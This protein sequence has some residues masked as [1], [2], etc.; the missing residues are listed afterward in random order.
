[1]ET[2]W[3]RDQP[4]L[5]IGDVKMTSRTWWPSLVTNGKSPPRGPAS[6]IDAL[7]QTFGYWAIEWKNHSNRQYIF[8]KDSFQMLVPSIWSNTLSCKHSF[9]PWKDH[10]QLNLMKFSKS[11]VRNRKYLCITNKQIINLFCSFHPVNLKYS[12]QFE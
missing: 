4:R 2:L 7:L 12:S 5:G 6:P 3:L 9:G 1:M 10:S 8:L 11:V